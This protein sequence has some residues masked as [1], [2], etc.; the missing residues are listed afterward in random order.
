MIKRILKRSIREPI[1]CIAVILFAASFA[2]ILCYLH[3]SQKAEQENYESTFHSIPV[4]FEITKL[5]GNRLDES[6]YIEDFLA[7][8]FFENSVFEPNFYPLVSDVQVRMSHSGTLMEEQEPDAT[9]G[10]GSA[11]KQKITKRMVGIT[12][13]N[14]AEEL[15][16]EFGGMIEWYDGFDESVFSTDRFVCVVPSNYIDV[17]EVVLSFRYRADG[18]SADREYTCSFVIAGRYT[19]DGNHKLYCPYGAMEQIYSKLGEPKKVQYLMGRL[20]SNDDL[21]LLRET[22]SHWFAEPNPMGEQTLWGKYGY[23]HYPFAM[24]IKDSLLKRLVSDMQNSMAINRAAAILVFALSAGAGFLTGFLVIRSRK[25]EIALMRT[26]GTSNRTICTELEIGQI[27]CVAVGVIL[28]GSYALWEP[29]G[30]LCLFAGIYI[31]G[32]TAALPVF[33]RSNLLA[34]MKEDE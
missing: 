7:D 18:T 31:A 34:T 6:A 29:L 30:Q 9:A 27:L 20:S 24:D 32:L 10:N 11:E 2:V 23:E 1:T 17:S 15:T 14:V 19:D 26:L 28:G 8:L 13:V 22:A 5:N 3:Q 12:S 4:E 21:E 16:P 25:R 33:M